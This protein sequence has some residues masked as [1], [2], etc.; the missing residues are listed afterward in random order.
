VRDW[1]D[2]FTF[3]S[4]RD[5]YNPW[6][7]VDYLKNKKVGA[8]WANTSSNSLAGKLIREGNVRVKETM[9]DLLEG[10]TF[11]TRIDE[12]IVFGE[13][14]QSEDA[15]WSLLLASG[16]L[17]VEAFSMD[18]EWGREE[19][20]LVLTNKEVRMMF[21]RMIGGWFTGKYAEVYNNFAKALLRDDLDE[22]NI[23]MNEVAQETFSMFD[24]GKRASGRIQPERKEDDAIVIEFKVFRP[25]KEGTLEDTVKAAHAQI[26]E[27]RGRTGGQGN[28]G[29][30]DTEIWIRV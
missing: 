30:E 4:R 5:I 18:E 19:Y 24:T 11:H 8:Y 20:D 3:G 6:S 22:M 13:L 2:G 21:E 28:L 23:Y 1:Y 26:E 10:K 7:I 12:Q 25:D 27:I 14:D 9:D 16:Y 15:V 29:R 17:R